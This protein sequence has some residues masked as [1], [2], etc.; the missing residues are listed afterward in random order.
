MFEKRSKVL[1]V[2]AVL[3]VIYS[4]YL[5]TYFLGVNSSATSDTE[6]IGGA[7]ATAMV[8]PHMALMVIGS[9]FSVL[10]FFKRKPGFALAAAILITV[11]AVLFM[12]YAMFALPIAILGY[13]GYSKQKKINLA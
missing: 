11:A 7:L 13:V 1:F 2:S 10:G 3:A 12:L 8:M 5:V 9:I 4:I 6:I